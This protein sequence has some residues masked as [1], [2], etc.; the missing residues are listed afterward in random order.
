MYV[1]MYIRIHVSIHMCIQI[2]MYECTQKTKIK[3]DIA[4]PYIIYIEKNIIWYWIR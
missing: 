4:S 3:H 1:H 2:C